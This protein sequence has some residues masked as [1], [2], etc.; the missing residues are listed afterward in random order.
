MSCKHEYGDM[1]Y[2]SNPPQVKCIK[3]GEFKTV[4]KETKL[5]SVEGCDK[6]HRA[7]GYCKSH[8]YKLWNTG[9]QPQKED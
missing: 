8:Y 7:K 3:C 2:M 6:P 5:C 9:V 4:Q 1:L